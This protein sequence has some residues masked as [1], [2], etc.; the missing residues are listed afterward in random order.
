[1][2]VECYEKAQAIREP[3]LVRQDAEEALRA[4]VHDIRSGL[5]WPKH[6]A[7]Y[8]LLKARWPVLLHGSRIDRDKNTLRVPEI[9][10]PTFPEI[11][12]P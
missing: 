5:N 6:G 2:A 10:T 11:L 12:A 3:V 4:F 9:L 8:K 1:M 7:A